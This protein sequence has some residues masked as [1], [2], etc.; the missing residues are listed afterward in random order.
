MGI[1]CQRETPSEKVD[2]IFNV[3]YGFTITG[4]TIILQDGRKMKYTFDRNSLSLFS[5]ENDTEEIFPVV[6]YWERGCAVSFSVILNRNYIQEI[7]Y[8]RRDD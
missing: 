2:E 4:D 5:E 1:S 7:S 3:D 6:D 8:R